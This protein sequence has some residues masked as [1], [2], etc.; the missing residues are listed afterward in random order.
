MGHD[1]HSHGH[2]HGHHHH[3]DPNAGDRRVA[4]AVGINLLL[5]AAQIVGGVVA[6]SLAL[7]ADAIHNLS[8]AMALVIAY[9]ARRI[10]RRPADADMPFGYARAEA[11][12]AL[13]N[14]TT[15]IVIGVYLVYEAV[16]RFISPEPVDGWLIVA[17]AA[18]A[19]VVDA[20]TA[21]VT[22]RMAKTSMNI[23]AAF[24]H[25]VADALG[26]IGV[27]V[28]G[29]AVALYDWRFVDPLVTLMIAG[30]ILWQSFREIGGVIRHLMLG[31]PPGIEA[32]DVV[33]AIRDVDGVGG[34]H[35]TRIWQLDEH[36]AALDAHIV[37]AAG[38][39][40]DAD[41]IKQEVKN[42][43]TAAF[44]IRQTTLE[45]E[46]ALHACDAPALYGRG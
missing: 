33:G 39:W 3:I 45:L 21:L 38:R 16:L 7:I 36:A 15:L 6:G 31:R 30:Y 13:I 43:L 34:V 4:F 2:G 40:T 5:T 9:A 20:A 41:A 18:V 11:V 44:E 14:Y 32:D 12:A 10:A 19:L 37:I 29:V 42:R 24:L 8:D 23:R 26:S 27:I 1:G 22:F 35:H 17:I 28:A 25:N 46:C